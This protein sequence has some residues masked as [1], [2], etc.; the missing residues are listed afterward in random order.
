VLPFIRITA[1]YWH[2]ICNMHYT[3]IEYRYASV[4][5]QGENLV[6][7]TWQQHH[8]MVSANYK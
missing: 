8:S 6:D 3:E 5:R 4:A 1:V 2:N 7:I